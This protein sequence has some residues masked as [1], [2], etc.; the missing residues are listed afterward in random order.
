[1]EVKWRI[2]DP[3]T[4]HNEIIVKAAERGEERPGFCERFV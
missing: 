2:A 1:M 4:H 3:A